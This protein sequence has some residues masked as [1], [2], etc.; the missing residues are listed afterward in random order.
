MAPPAPRRQ[1]FLFSLF[2]GGVEAIDRSIDV[3]RPLSSYG[4]GFDNT[5]FAAALRLGCWLRSRSALA[6]APP[7]LVVQQ[8]LARVDQLAHPFARARMERAGRAMAPPAP[9][10]QQ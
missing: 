4:V 8:K 9:R 6:A 1:Q 3:D 5:R 10:R 2:A 7:A